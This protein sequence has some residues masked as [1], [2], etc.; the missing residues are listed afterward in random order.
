MALTQG[1]KR[2]RLGTPSNGSFGYP[3]AP[4]EWVWRG[5][6]V[7]LNAACQLQRVQTAGT[8]VVVGLA[9]RDYSNVGNSGP[10]SDYVQADRGWWN[11]PLAGVGPAN[12]NQPVYATDD[13]TLSL[14][15]ATGAVAGATNA[16]NGTVGTVTATGSSQPMIGDYTV[17]FT[18]ATAFTVTN[19]AGE[20]IGS[21]TAGTAF[22]AA[23]VGFTIT[24]GTTA[25]AANDSFT[26]SV[27]GLLVGT[28]SG[29]DKGTPYVR[30][31][32]S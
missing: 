3:V 8:V 18:S 13:N 7:G 27:G 6:I 2:Y 28:L 17:T 11:L 22:S 19:P 1:T 30:I 5:S 32:G 25:F 20:T 9:D 29:F 12:I 31:Q 10:S 21:G 14:T 23:G 4:G 26:V 24:S 15:P 16:G